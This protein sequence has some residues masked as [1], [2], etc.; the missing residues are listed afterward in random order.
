MSPPEIASTSSRRE[1]SKALSVELHLIACDH[2]DTILLRLPIDR[3]VLVD[4]NLCNPAIRRQFFDW[5]EANKVTRLEYIFQTHPDFDHFCGMDKVLEYFTKDG[6]SVGTWCDT[7]LSTTEV[8]QEHWDKFARAENKKLQDKLDDLADAGLI[9]FM[10]IDSFTEPLSPR[11]YVDIVNLIPIAPQATG[12]RK[13]RRL[14]LKRLKNNPN[15]KLDTNALSIVLA[16]VVHASSKTFSALLASDI[17]AAD[18]ESA[19]ET[20]A[21]RLSDDAAPAFD[22]VKIPHHGS[23]KS[24]DKRLCSA[25]R[26]GD[27]L[28]VACVT[29]GTRPALPSPTV[30]RDY[31]DADW[32][33]M[34]TTIRKPHGKRSTLAHVVAR[35][36]DPSYTAS[37]FNLKLS[38][39]PGSGLSSEPKAAIVGRSDLDCYEKTVSKRD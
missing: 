5:I 21:R 14:E 25:R 13:V 22:V 8:R 30:L 19:L 9:E 34:N 29:A 1:S 31:M 38:W 24:H 28:C 32:A 7:G 20:C 26:S 27:G 36:P 17:W 11:G 33:V 4:C 2:G 37:S 18:V 16:L 3:W 39:D 12:K 6:R 15:A 23:I 10:E 35:A